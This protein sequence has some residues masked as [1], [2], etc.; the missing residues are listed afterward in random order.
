M[1]LVGCYQT[2]DILSRLDYNFIQKLLQIQYE[3]IRGFEQ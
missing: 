3:T 2:G 1:N